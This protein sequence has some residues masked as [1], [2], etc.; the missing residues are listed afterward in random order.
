[1]RSVSPYGGINSFIGS[2]STCV[3]PSSWI[4]SQTR[5]FPL[6]FQYWQEAQSVAKMLK[7]PSLL[8]HGALTKHHE[9]YLLNIFQTSFLYPLLH[10][11]FFWSEPLNTFIHYCPHPSLFVP[12]P[13]KVVLLSVTSQTGYT[14]PPHPSPPTRRHLSNLGYLSPE[15]LTCLRGMVLL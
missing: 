4:L 15:S 13:P 7:R 8:S 9:F 2:S 11:P 12:L 10:K 1:M 5:F 14:P 3:K 6:Y